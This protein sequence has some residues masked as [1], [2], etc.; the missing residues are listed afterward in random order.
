M[1]CGVVQID[2]LL[3]RIYIY[4]SGLYSVVESTACSDFFVTANAI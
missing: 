2:G 4:R 1:W 3:M